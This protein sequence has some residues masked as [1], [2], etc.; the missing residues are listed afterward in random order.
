MIDPLRLPTRDAEGAVV[1]V[2][3]TP[4]ASP[5]KMKWDQRLGAFRLSRVLPTGMVFPFDF[6][7]IPGTRAA[8][9]D[10][11]DIVVLLGAPVCTGSIVACRL[12]AVLEAEQQED[13]A[14]DWVRNDRLIGVPVE[15]ATMDEI[16]DDGDLDARTLRDLG[17]FFADYN[18]LDGKRFRVLRHRGPKAAQRLLEEA[19]DAG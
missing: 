2:I 5:N 17:A 3:E 11:L 14:T 9:G 7:F 1:A 12:V 10:P 4:R 13:D 18:H 15:D 19:L 6:G 8:D 16:R